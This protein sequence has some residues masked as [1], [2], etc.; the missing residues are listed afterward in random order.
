M[1]HRLLI[2]FVV[3]LASCTPHRNMVYLQ[4]KAAQGDLIQVNQPDF[5]IRPGDILH[6]RVM[7][8]DRESSLLFNQDESRMT[9]TTIG[10]NMGLYIYGYTVNQAGNILLPVVGEAE[11]AQK[12]VEQA[13]QTIQQRI[14]EYLVGATVSVKLANFSVTVLGEVNSP[15]VFYIYDNELTLLDLLGMAGDLTDFANRKVNLV[16]QEASGLK[17]HTVDLTSRQMV[18]SELFYLQPGDL[19]YVEPQPVKRLGFSQFPFALIFSTI[20]TTL[21]LISYFS[22]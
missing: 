18:S 8:L 6:V 4:D 22:N 17:F 12:T 16:R 3:L 11:V 7:T 15:G 20:S 13:Q 14:D 2:I 21:L 5:L 9:S 10:S 1:K 19:V